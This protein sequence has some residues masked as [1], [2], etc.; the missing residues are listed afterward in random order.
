[1]TISDDGRGM[2]AATRERMFE[3][4]FTTRESGHG[5]GLA[6]VLG[7]ARG[8][9][10]KLYVHSVVGVGSTIRLVVPAITAEPTA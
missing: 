9:G 8:A 3:P 1:M 2:D 4:F 5:L 10:A 7:V 6:A